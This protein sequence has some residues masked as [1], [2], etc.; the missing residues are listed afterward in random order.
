MDFN[1]T[2]LG[3]ANLKMTKKLC[4]GKLRQNGSKNSQHLK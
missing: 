2:S 4:G 3:S 1:L